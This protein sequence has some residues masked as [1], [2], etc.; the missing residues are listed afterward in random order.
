MTTYEKIKDRLKDIV[1]TTQ[2]IEELRKACYLLLNIVEESAVTI[3]K[4]SAEVQELRDEVNL[5]KGEKPKPKF[6]PKGQPEDHSS[7]DERNPKDAPKEPKRP[8]AKKHL[9]K[10]TRQQICAVDISKLPN[11]IVFKGYQSVIVQDIIITADNI[12]FQKE[13]FYSPSLGKSFIGEVP[14]GYNGDFGPNIKAQTLSL[15]N[16]FNM[17]ESAIVDYMNTYGILIS[18]ASVARIILDGHK[19]FKEEKTAI[20]NAGLRSTT[21]Q[22]IDDT[23]A[24]VDGMQHYT[25]ILCN[26]FYTAYFTRHD[27]S[28]ITLLDIL[29]NGNFNFRF[30]DFAYEIMAEMKLPDKALVKLKAIQPSL[31]L[32]RKAV[33]ELLS[34]LY[35]EKDR[36]QTTKRIILEASAISAYRNHPLTIPILLCDD[37]PQFKQITQELALCWIHEGRHY[38][39]LT[40]LSNEFKEELKAFIGQF[41]DYYR[42]L[43]QFKVQPIGSAAEKLSAS[44]DKLFSSQVKYSALAER[45]SKTHAH[46]NELLMVLRHPEIPL[47]NNSA[48]LGARAQA[49]KRD[50]SFHTKTDLGT[51]AKDTMMT[52]VNTAK[53]LKVN[54]YNYLRDRISKTMNMRS[55]ADEII[56]QSSA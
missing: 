3:K 30:D 25:H 27:K 20:I 31:V 35:P 49:R 41:W 22:H 45:M 15:H 29:S 56:I 46:K 53:K 36:Y 47:H 37:A 23:G 43:L 16:A 18:S 32:D 5:L 34:M 44:F 9:I 17:T 6:K 52:V 1:T 14:E 39:K 19:Q 2:D 8:K 12:E 42:E 38:K 4:F 55:L 54:V 48:E 21:F 24:K 50:I 7:E 11:D 10:V 51:M 40:P 26:P 33:D 28:R 13:V